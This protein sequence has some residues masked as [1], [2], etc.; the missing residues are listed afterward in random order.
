M[1][2]L[3]LAQALAMARWRLR[4]RN[5]HLHGEPGVG[6]HVWRRAPIGWRARVSVTGQRLDGQT[7]IAATLDDVG[8]ERERRSAMSFDW[9]GF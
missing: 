9:L 3:G 4:I 5:R 6:G 8:R 1:P 7:E 2:P